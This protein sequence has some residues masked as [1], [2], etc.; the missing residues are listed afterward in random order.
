PARRKFLKTIETE[1]G[2][3]A[4]KVARIA[5]RET[6]TLELMER[7]WQGRGYMYSLPPDLMIKEQLQPERLLMAVKGDQM[8]YFD[9]VN[10]VRHQGVMGEDN[11]L[12][13]NIGVFRALI[14]ADEALLHRLYWV[15]FSSSAQRWSMTLKPKQD[16]NYGFSIIISGLAQKQ[17]DTIKVKQPDGDL[18]E[19]SLQPDTN[20]H[21]VEATV[22][23]LY[24][25]LLGE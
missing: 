22:K 12:S 1:M 13:L 19:L 16:S 5:Y 24:R 17:P 15:D 10:D 7:P 20:G 11:P 18:S 2:H 8:F 23:R 3:I 9:P 21:D 4:D 14:N 25:E 6:R